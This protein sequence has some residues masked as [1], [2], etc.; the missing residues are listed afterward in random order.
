MEVW[1]DPERSTWTREISRGH[2]ADNGRS[3]VASRQHSVPQEAF[4][5]RRGAGLHLRRILRCQG[6]KQRRNE[7]LLIPRCCHAV[8]T[9]RI[10]LPPA[11]SLSLQTTPGL[12]AK[13]LALL[14]RSAPGAGRERGTGWLSTRSVS[15]F[16]Q[17]GIDAVP[18]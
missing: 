2:A 15:R 18:P 11:V 16:S 6:I 3:A 17:K 7:P 9:V 5:C 12:W 8:P 14:R 13:S 1:K 10:L 4:S